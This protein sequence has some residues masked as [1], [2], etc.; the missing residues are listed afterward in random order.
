MVYGILSRKLPTTILDTDTWKDHTIMH[1]DSLSI[2]LPRS[3]L[4]ASFQYIFYECDGYCVAEDD[5]W[6]DLGYHR[7]GLRR[8]RHQPALRHQRMF[9]RCPSGAH[10]PPSHPRHALA[11][12]LVADDRGVDQVHH[13]YDARRQ[14]R[15]GGQP[16]AAGIGDAAHPRHLD[17]RARHAARH[18]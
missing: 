15:R 11:D 2:T 12:L 13:F 8:H 18:L 5:G 1:W 14:S 10:R 16:G 17:R 4:A 6:R 3:A 9:R 7:R